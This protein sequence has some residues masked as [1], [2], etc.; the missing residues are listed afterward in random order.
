MARELAHTKFYPS[1]NQYI[2]CYKSQLSTFLYTP[3]I[4]YLFFSILNNLK[5]LKCTSGFFVDELLLKIIDLHSIAK[6]DNICTVD[7]CPSRCKVMTII[8]KCAICNC[9]IH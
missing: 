1:Q 8:S 5:S 7:F 6:F 2:F 4:C 3:I 9:A